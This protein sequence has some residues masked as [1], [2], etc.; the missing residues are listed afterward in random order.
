MEIIFSASSITGGGKTVCPAGITTCYVW[1]LSLMVCGIWA[2][3]AMCRKSHFIWQVPACFH[4]CPEWLNSEWK[5]PLTWHV[6]APA[7]LTIL[8]HPQLCYYFLLR[9]FLSRIPN[10]ICSNSLVTERHSPQAREH[11]LNTSHECWC[12]KFKTGSGT[13]ALRALEKEQKEL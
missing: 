13:K 7:A 3:M 1:P 4:Y 11:Y 8:T 10:K 6:A 9:K 2:V 5:V 12:S